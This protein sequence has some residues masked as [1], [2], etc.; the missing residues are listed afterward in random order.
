MTKKQNQIVAR[1]SASNLYYLHQCYDNPSWAKECAYERCKN[2]C[3]QASGYDFKIIGY[4]CMMFSVG[5]YYVKDG[6]KM[7]HY[8]TNHNALDFIVE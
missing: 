5:F 7:F 1:H 6:K 2:K 8:E 3:A 4:N